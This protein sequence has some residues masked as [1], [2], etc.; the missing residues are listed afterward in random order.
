MMR[1]MARFYITTAI[2]YTN[3]SP[4]IGFALEL[5]QADVVAR[6]RRMLG[7]E[8]YFLT[9]TDEHGTKIMRSAQ[10][11]SMPTQQ[12][13]DQIAGKVGELATRLNISNTDFIRTSDQ[14]RHWPAAQKIW[15]AM[16]ERGDIYKKS[17][18]GYYCIGHEAFIKQSEL[19]DGVCPL[20]KS[21]PEIVKEDN[22]FFRL[23]KYTDRV[24]KLLESGDLRIVPESRK[25]EILNLLND[26]EDVSF[27]RPASQLPWG[28]P[29]PDD[30][31]QT[32]YVWADALTNYISALGYGTDEKNMAFWPADVHL[33]GK[34]IIRFHAIFWPAMLLSAGLAVPKS[35]Y[36]HGFIT[37]D[38]EKMSK[39]LGNVIDPFYLLDRYSTEQ[40]RY[41]MVRELQSTEDG[42]FSY[43]A[44][45]SRY[46][47]DLANGLGNLVQR[48]ATLLESKM[49]SKA[50]YA[51]D[52]ELTEPALGQVLGDTEY[53]RAFE[54]FRLHD[55]AAN[56]WAKIGLANAYLNEKQPWKEDGSEQQKT[57]TSVA[58]MIMHIAWMLQPFMPET[59]QKVAGIFGVSSLKRALADGQ[60]LAIRKGT[61][62]FPRR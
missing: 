18:E 62:L 36:V 26:A 27:S 53:H 43:K 49:G 12:F 40:V 3:A 15:R 52:L 50:V 30:P 42:D 34:D 48:V 28:I 19:V 5:V 32:M 23:T 45:E 59:A 33:I 41:F 22:W 57:L 1:A 6:Y 4:H 44:L 60:E 25:E 39:T 16:S 7:D 56:I 38:G 47:S 20:H 17:Y 14:K 2:V 58:A 37:V 54:Q 9:G 29:V 46:N 10:H 51:A 11:A 55:A 35:I 13:V 61:A 8:V 21:K 31:T 24:R